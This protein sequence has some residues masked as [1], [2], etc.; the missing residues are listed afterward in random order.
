MKTCIVI[1]SDDFRIEDNPA[2]YFACENYENI[3]PLYCYDEN[4]LDRKLGSAAKVF[5]FN[6]LKSFDNLLKKNYNINLII[7]EGNIIKILQEIFRKIKIDAI[8]FNHSYT[9]KQIEIEENIKNE[10]K[11]SDLQSFKGK[12]L[13]EPWEIKVA[14]T[15]NYYKVFT[16]FS[17]ECLRSL[18]LIKS[19]LKK[20]DFIFS[21]HNIETLSLKDLNLIPVNEGNWHNELI[22][23]WTFDYEKIE[24]NFIIFLNNKIINYKLNRNFPN[25]NGNAK[26]SPYLRFGMLSI[27]KCFNLIPID[28]II[29]DN[30]FTLEFFW[31]EFAY[32]VMFYNQ[33]IAQEELKTNYKKFKWIKNEEFFEQ[34]KK[35]ET[36]FDIVDAGMKELWITGFMHNRIRMIVASFLTKDLLI[37]W[38]LGEHWFWETLIDADVAVNPFSWQWVFGSGFD[39]AP[40][41]RIFNPDLQREKFDSNKEYCK[42]WLDKNWK[43]N[44]IIDHNLQRN[45]ALEKYKEIL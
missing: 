4:Y 39:A 36:G 25:E 15:G 8:Y 26:I 17:K 16:P 24:N 33:N 10:F 21:K 27:R 42:K 7:K 5:L 20:P 44:R 40:Y 2:L 11:K 28:Y 1:F 37:N 9:K 13:F 14:S 29:T 32:H 19:T 12:L 31:R 30:Q 23:N 6:V 18:S 45:I 22:Q 43:A 38:K 41:F 35:S 34:W 3:I